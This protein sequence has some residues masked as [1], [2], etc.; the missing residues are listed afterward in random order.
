MTNE[1]KH[2]G[3]RQEMV[4]AMVENLGGA[5]ETARKLENSHGLSPLRI[6]VEIIGGVAATATQLGMSRSRMDE[7]IKKGPDE[8]KGSY[9]RKISELTGIPVN[10][11]MMSGPAVRR[12]AKRKAGK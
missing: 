6:A 3:F 9:L 2:D 10:T 7:L 5:A 11:L 1:S 8:M 12:A 4:K